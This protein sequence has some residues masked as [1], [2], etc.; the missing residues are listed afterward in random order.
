MNGVPTLNSITDIWNQM[1]RARRRAA[2]G[3]GV[4]T[5]P[6]RHVLRQ[7]GPQPNMVK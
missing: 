5:I 7:V 2:P 4:F 6:R 1:R 3:P